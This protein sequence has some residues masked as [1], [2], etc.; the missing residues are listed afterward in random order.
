LLDLL[1]GAWLRARHVAQRGRQLAGTRRQLVYDR[2]NLPLQRVRQRT[3][4]CDDY[5]QHQRRADGAGHAE[6]LR[7]VDGRIER[8]EQQGAQDQWEQHRLHVLEKEN[9]DGSR[10]QRERE[11]SNVDR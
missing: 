8:V 1:H 11:V 7:P 9:H 2:E 4:A 5:E 3:A 10:E 6:P